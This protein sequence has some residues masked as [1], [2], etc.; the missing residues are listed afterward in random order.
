MTAKLKRSKRVSIW[1]QIRTP[2]EDVT[3]IFSTLRDVLLRQRPAF[4]RRPVPVRPA[5]TVRPAVYAQPF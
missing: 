2:F 4:A 1:A 3:F 5:A